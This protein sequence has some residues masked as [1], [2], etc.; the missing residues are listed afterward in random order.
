MHGEHIGDARAHT[1]LGEEDTTARAIIQHS[2]GVATVVD[3]A[4]RV[5]LLCLLVLRYAGQR[6]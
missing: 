5:L 6:R 4:H 2:A 3:V 1:R